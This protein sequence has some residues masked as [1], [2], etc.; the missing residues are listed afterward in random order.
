MQVGSEL[1]NGVWEFG[2]SGG[3]RGGVGQRAWPMLRLSADFLL[4]TTSRDFQSSPLGSL[5]ANVA[6][7]TAKLVAEGEMRGV[8]GCRR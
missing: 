3:K 4:L 2:K 5:Q 7:I 1:W 8:D 6:Q